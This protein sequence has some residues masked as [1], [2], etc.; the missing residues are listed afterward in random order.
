MG[1]CERKAVLRRAGVQGTPF[2]IRTLRKFWMG[3]EVHNALKRAVETEMAKSNTLEL[4]GHELS[5]R[6]EEYHV[7]GRVDSVVRVNSV[8][9]AWE[10]KS[11]ASGAFKY[12][13][14]PKPEHVLQLG[15]Y[16]T[17]PV[18][19]PMALSANDQPCPEDPDAALDPTWKPR[20]NS[21][22]PDKY[23]VAMCEYCNAQLSG[24]QPLVIER[25]RLIYWSKDD[26]L[27]QEYIVESTPALRS[28][29]KE[30][31]RRLEEL[32]DI[33]LAN[34]DNIPPVLELKQ[35]TRVTGTGKSRKKEPFF[36][37]KPGSW[38]PAG[39][40]KMEFDHRCI[41]KN[42]TNPCEYYQNACPASAWPQSVTTD[43]AQGKEEDED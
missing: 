15:V 33:Y 18:G 40:A 19:V 10:Y 4:I 23:G 21:R 35:A 43:P 38:G 3:D 22:G 36:Y 37:L 6:D 9:E 41:S 2:D 13:D 26:A 25:G 28:N 8:P 30:T 29:V 7:A 31:L 20:H 24:P 14:L 17:F 12:G 39:T 16:L 27:M 11:S 5:V 1:G 42:G 32:F 34:P